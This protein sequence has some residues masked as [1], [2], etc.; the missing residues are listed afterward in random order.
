MTVS[1][2]WA[3]AS[4]PGQTDGALY[5]EIETADDD[6]LLAVTVPES[7]A[8]HAEIHEELADAEGRMTMREV[9]GGLALEGGETTLFEPGG[10]HVMLVDLAAP[11]VDGSSFDATF[12]L[13]RGDAV[14][15]TV[16]IAQSAP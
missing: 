7:V 3:R 5:F 1:S 4:A 9:A 2:A 15:V 12:E 11:L 10:L 8:D 14:T 6:V 13:E 16:R